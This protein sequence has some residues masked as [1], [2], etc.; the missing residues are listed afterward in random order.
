[1]KNQSLTIQEEILKK[2]D[3]V[4]LAQPPQCANTSLRSGFNNGSFFIRAKW[5][6]L[7][8]N[9]EEMLHAFFWNVY[10]RLNAMVKAIA[11]W[12]NKEVISFSTLNGVKDF[13]RE[14]LLSDNRI[15]WYW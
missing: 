4:V 3:S 10:K 12:I 7:L 14:D 5:H 11:G 9:G 8:K 15:E 2:R 6:T 1:M 13:Q